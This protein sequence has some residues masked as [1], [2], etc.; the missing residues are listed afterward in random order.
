MPVNLMAA[1]VVCRSAMPATVF[2]STRP[3]WLCT[4]TSA[5]ASHTRTS[6]KLVVTIGN[7]AD[8]LHFHPAVAAV[9][10]QGLA[11]VGDAH[12]AEAVGDFGGAG[13]VAGAHPAV[14]VD[15]GDVALVGD[16]FDVAE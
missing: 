10:G 7:A 2:A 1:K 14:A 9:H 13:D 8:V 11:D 12:L 15:H 3:F 16:H 4:V 5:F 6:P